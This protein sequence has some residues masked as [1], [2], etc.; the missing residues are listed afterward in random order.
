MDYWS[1]LFCSVC[2]FVVSDKSYKCMVFQQTNK[3]TKN[4]ILISNEIIIN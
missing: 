2:L 3:Q 4:L 1:D